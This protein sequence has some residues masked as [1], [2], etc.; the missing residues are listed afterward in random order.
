MGDKLV[1]VRVIGNDT[2]EAVVPEW[3][4]NRLVTYTSELIHKH[5]EAIVDRVCI[6]VSDADDSTPLS[7]AMAV[8]VG[9]MGDFDAP[10]KD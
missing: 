3:A 5:P 9:L 8:M 7:R 6:T 2:A 10:S 4:A 1:R